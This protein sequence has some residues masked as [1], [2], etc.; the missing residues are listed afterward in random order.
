MSDINGT[1]SKQTIITDGYCTADSFS[2]RVEDYN[3]TA[4]L[5]LHACP[6]N[7]DPVS[8][9]LTTVG[10]LVDILNEGI[11][12]IGAAV[13]EDIQVD[14]DEFKCELVEGVYDENS[15]V[16]N[17]ADI[18]QDI[19]EQDIIDYLNAQNGV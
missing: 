3:A 1:T 18:T 8:D 15:G 11:D 16:C 4:D 12:S 9:E 19:S 17:G 5:V 10:V 7:E 6:L 14:I 13:T 2:T